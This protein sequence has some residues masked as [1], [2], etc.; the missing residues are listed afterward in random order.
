M[1]VKGQG[2]DLELGLSITVIFLFAQQQK[3]VESAG[4]IL[5]SVYELCDGVSRI[6]S[7][8]S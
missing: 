5:T 6:I 7:R 2:E 3:S 4:C 1:E 8:G